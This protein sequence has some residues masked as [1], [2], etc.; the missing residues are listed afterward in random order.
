MN[1]VFQYILT[2][3]AN[4]KRILA[5]F[6]SVK[7]DLRVVLLIALSIELLLEFILFKI[8]ECFSGA[9]T[10]GQLFSKLSLSFIASFIFYYL[11]VH[12]KSQN[13]KRNGYAVAIPL[14]E[15]IICDTRSI[16]TELHIELG[17]SS[18]NEDI[19]LALNQLTL[20]STAN[21]IVSTSPP[22]YFTWLEYLASYHNNLIGT[23]NSIF[24]FTTLCDSDFIKRANDIQY[25]HFMYII[26][27]LS[28]NRM[29]LSPSMYN[30]SLNY[31]SDSFIEHIA[32]INDLEIYINEK[33]N[34]LSLER[35][36]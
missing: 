1:H 18:S 4:R 14:A 19:R 28:A 34:A 5:D 11:V 2:I 22:R 16:L 25:S 23:V 7:K 26:G 29:A 32:L 15:R 12:L 17:T 30:Q 20:S 8:P 21:V 35:N 24:N 31:L 13:D 33:A 27:S 36:T 10:I 6:N 9:S 3:W